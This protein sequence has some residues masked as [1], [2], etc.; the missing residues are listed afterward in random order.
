MPSP[1]LKSAIPLFYLPLCWQFKFEANLES[2]PRRSI[3]QFWVIAGRNHYYVAWQCIN[4]QQ[5]GTHNAFDFAR[6][7]S[8][9]PLFSHRIKLVEQ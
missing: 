6:F 8:I 2:T 7:M 9:A 4:L 1:P 5:K 3:K